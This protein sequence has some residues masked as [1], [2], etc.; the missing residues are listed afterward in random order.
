MNQQKFSQVL[1]QGWGNVFKQRFENA[2]IVRKYSPKSTLK[3]K[4]A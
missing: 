3:E 2:V 4:N 1:R